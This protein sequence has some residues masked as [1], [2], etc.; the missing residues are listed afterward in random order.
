M[1]GRYNLKADLE[2]IQ[3]RFEFLQSDLTCSPRYNIAPTQPV[4][5]VTKGDGRR[6]ACFRWGIIP[7]CSRSAATGNPLINVR[8]ET[9]AERSSFASPWPAGGA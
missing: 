9:V 4:L 5:A 2:D 3:R 6:A 8:A 7:S 1:C